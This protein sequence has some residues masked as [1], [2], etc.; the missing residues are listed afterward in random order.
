ML[1]CKSLFAAARCQD[2]AAWFTSCSSVAKNKLPPAATRSTLQTFTMSVL[3][4]VR[5]DGDGDGQRDGIGRST[6]LVLSNRAAAAG[7]THALPASQHV[8]LTR[9]CA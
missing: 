3:L 7:A 2:A 5:H 4:E 9:G 1:R 8:F 6:R